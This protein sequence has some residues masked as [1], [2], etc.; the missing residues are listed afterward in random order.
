M[1]MK[2]I[3]R[4]FTSCMLVGICSIA[5]GQNQNNTQPVSDLPI[6]Y[7]QRYGLRI[8]ADLYKL[9]RSFYDKDYR[10]LELNADYKFNKN[11]YIAGEIGNE[12]ITN[13]EENLY[14][15]TAEGSYIKI[16]VD[17]NTHENWMDRE[18]LIY[19]GVRYGFSTFSQTLNSYQIYT[20]DPYFGDQ[21]EYP[22]T[23]YSGLN[24]HWLEMVAGIKT[25]VFNNIFMGFQ[26]QLKSLLTQKQPDNFENLYIPGFHK[27]YSGSIGVGFSYS[28][29]YFIPL[30]KSSKGAFVMPE[31]EP[32]KEQ[33]EFENLEDMG[34]P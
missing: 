8:G 21:T 24:A 9:T 18:D 26:F 14:N 11:I 15:Y 12:K 2:S 17:L 30:Y 28:V 33:L 19:V 13:D 10:G 3:L 25:R 6:S 7:P 16:G 29:S 1:I 34:N 27:K 22:N 5:I 31:E 23:K 4:F 20:T 32:N